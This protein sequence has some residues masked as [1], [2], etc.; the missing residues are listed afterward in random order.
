MINQTL[1]GFGA[2]FDSSPPLESVVLIIG[3][4]GT[5]KSSFAYAVAMNLCKMMNSGGLYLSL[6]QN[7][8]MFIRNLKS[9]GI[10]PSNR[11]HI[12]DFSTFM[13]S[14]GTNSH[15]FT[16]DEYVDFVFRALSMELP[17]V[18]TNLR[19][20]ILDSLNALQSLMDV[21]EAELRRKMNDFFFRLRKKG[22]LSLIIMEGD[23][24]VERDEYYLVDGII[25]LG[26]MHIG[27]DIKRY[28]RIRKMRGCKHTLYPHILEVDGGIRVG[29]E[30][31]YE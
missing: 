3:R 12:I 26:I 13:D 17:D 21:S 24:D 5:L 7:R 19:C 14:L 22:I 23:A 6:E 8:N 28:V 25:E 10:M 2:M 9:I 4:A 27:T 30:L 20:F 1:P 11:L 31:I 29:G 15:Y 16:H 18:G